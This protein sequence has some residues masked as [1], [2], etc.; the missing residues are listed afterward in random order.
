MCVYGHH[1]LHITAVVI[2]GTLL[3]SLITGPQLLVSGTD[4]PR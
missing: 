4:G 2:L 1:C 3:F